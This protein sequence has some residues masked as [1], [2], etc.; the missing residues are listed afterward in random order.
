MDIVLIRTR[1]RKF[2]RSHLSIVSR[3]LIDLDQLA[4]FNALKMRQADR[5]FSFKGPA[6]YSSYPS[7]VR[8]GT[9]ILS[10]VLK[11]IS[12]SHSRLLAVVFH[13]R[14]YRELIFLPFDNY[15]VD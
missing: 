7:P 13:L 6:C 15:S 3:K 14:H 4:R 11:R 1:D 10:V 5:R 8:I 9:F 12:R 2:S